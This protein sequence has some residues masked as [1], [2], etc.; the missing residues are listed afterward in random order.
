M[1]VNLVRKIL[2]FFDFFYQKKIIYFLYQNSDI[3]SVIDVGAHHGETI[4]LFL[5]YFKLNIIY[6]FEPSKK[7]YKILTNQLYFLKKNNKNTKV[8]IFNLGLGEKNC[9]VFLNNTLESSSSTINDIN[10]ESN[11]YLR[12]I[13]NLMI[14][15]DQYIVDSEKI[16]VITLDDFF[17][18]KNLKKIDLLKIDT[19][20]YELNILKGIKKNAKNI[21]YIYF[22]HHYHNMIKKNYFF[23]DINKLLNR[24]NFTQ[25]FKIKMP[26]RKTFEYIYKNKSF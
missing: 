12:K 6:S 18:D 20:G 15:S 11:Y 17:D 2:N 1:I 23:S 9:E 25:V 7:N 22:E 3:K 5:K 24:Y 10:K 19:E 8:L 26:F 14:K 21:K 4:S 13:K 16:E